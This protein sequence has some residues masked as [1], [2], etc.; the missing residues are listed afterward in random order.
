MLSVYRNLHLKRKCRYFNR[1][2]ELMKL[3]PAKSTKT[4]LI[5][6][7]SFIMLLHV[8]TGSS[9]SDSM[10]PL[11][12]LKQTELTLTPVDLKS[13]KKSYSFFTSIAKHPSLFT[14]DLSFS[15]RIFQHTQFVGLKLKMLKKHVRTSQ[16]RVVHVTLAQNDDDDLSV[17]KG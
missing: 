17:L 1:I 9:G 11:R 2:F 6:L 8:S 10:A 5:W 16:M 4:P 12:N 13:V 15:T 14:G 3:L 7:V